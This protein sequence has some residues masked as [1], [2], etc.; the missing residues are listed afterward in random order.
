MR[1]SWYFSK[2]FK[3]EPRVA[4]LSQV[5]ER[6]REHGMMANIEINPPLALDHL[7]GKMVALAA[8]QL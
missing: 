8:R 5:A 4:L 7:T 6:C 1:A 2:A 3:G